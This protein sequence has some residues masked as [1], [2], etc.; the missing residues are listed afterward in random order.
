MAFS[1][2]LWCVINAK[3]VDKINVNLQQSGKVVLI[4]QSAFEK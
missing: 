3:I 2:F 4:W 1:L